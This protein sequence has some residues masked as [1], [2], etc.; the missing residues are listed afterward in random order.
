MQQLGVMTFFRDH[1]VLEHE[2]PIDALKRGN[3]MGNHDGRA[4]SDQHIHGLANLD[5][6]F[7]I[8]VGCGF[9][10]DH[11]RRIF[12]QDSSNGDALLLSHRQFD[13][14][15][16]NPRVIAFGERVDEFLRPRGAGHRFDFFLRRAQFAVRDI[17]T[18]RSIE[19]KRFLLHQSDLLAEK[20][21]RHVSEIH[22]ING[23]GSAGDIVKAKEQFD[24]CT[25]PGSAVAYERDM[26]ARVNAERQ[27]SENG[28]PGAIGKCDILEGDRASN[29]RNRR[30]D[31]GAVLDFGFGIQDLEHAISGG[32]RML[33]E[34][35]HGMDLVDRYIKQREIRKKHDEFA[36]G[37][38]PPHDFP[39]TVPEDQDRAQTSHEHHAR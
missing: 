28:N 34:M 39:R 3:A 20:R 5:F 27:A 8:D 36:D 12:E 24:Q 31:A 29:T 2:H 32:Q 23:D 18:H 37:Q 10:E 21:H 22:A 38:A 1:A 19:Q 7:G 13:A 17:V 16:A 14:S 6:R 15:L 30:G 35:I 4:V 26:F 25:F 33:K 9:V 11:D